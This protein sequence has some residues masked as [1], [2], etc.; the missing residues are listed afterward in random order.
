M[1]KVNLAEKLALFSEHWSPKIVDELNDSYIKLAR[2][3]GEFLWHSHEAEDEMFFVVKG[4][5]TIRFREEDIALESGE[6]LV[7][8]RG[9]EH[10]PV[11]E[12]EVEVLLIEKKTTRN[13]GNVQSERTVDAPEWI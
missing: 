12:D 4:R 7:V 13:T 9:V 5:L 8:P 3:K 11:A 2:L 1:N 10:M 6:F